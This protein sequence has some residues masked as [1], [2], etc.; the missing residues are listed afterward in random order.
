[1]FFSSQKNNWIK[2][3]TITEAKRFTVNGNAYYIE[4]SLFN[5]YQEALSKT[6]K[7]VEDVSKHGEIL[8]KKSD[9]YDWTSTILRFSDTT[10]EIRNIRPKHKIIVAQSLKSMSIEEF[11]RDNAVFHYNK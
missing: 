9:L 10:I 4:V 7:V 5:S 3:G 11:E 6:F 1:M 8:E 2:Y